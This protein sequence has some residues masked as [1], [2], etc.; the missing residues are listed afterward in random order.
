[1]RGRMG[2][3]SGGGG[4]FVTDEQLSRDEAVRAMKL[5]QAFTEA[6]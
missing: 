5:R 1:M 6:E 4:A 3:G 2:A